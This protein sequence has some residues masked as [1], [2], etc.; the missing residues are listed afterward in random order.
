MPPRS[1]A[2]PTRPNAGPGSATDS[3]T[4]RPLLAVGRSLQ[5]QGGDAD[6]PL[7]QARDLFAEMGARPGVRDCDAVLAVA[8]GN[9]A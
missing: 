4:R 2:S 6:G 8:P 5:A 7:R 9:I 1:P 3:S